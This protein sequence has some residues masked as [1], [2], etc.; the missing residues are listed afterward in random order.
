MVTIDCL[1][2][3]KATKVVSVNVKLVPTQHEL[4]LKSF[5]SA[6]IAGLGHIAASRET[7]TI[8][9]EKWV[10]TQQCCFWLSWVFSI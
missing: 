6:K 2:H 9:A 10:Y 5:Q 8:T 1:I 3:H 4:K 7:T